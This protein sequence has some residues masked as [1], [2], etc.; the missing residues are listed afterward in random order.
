MALPKFSFNVISQE[1]YDARRKEEAVAATT[2][3]LPAQPPRRFSVAFGVPGVVP[4]IKKKSDSLFSTHLNSSWVENNEERVAPKLKKKNEPLPVRSI[5][6]SLHCAQVT[7]QH[8]TCLLSAVGEM[9]WSLAPIFVIAGTSF[10][11]IVLVFGLFA[12]FVF[13][14]YKRIRL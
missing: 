11:K 3:A 12:T 14:S 10:W 13:F 6:S 2:A 4:K 9:K 8:K 5:H 7:T 1:E